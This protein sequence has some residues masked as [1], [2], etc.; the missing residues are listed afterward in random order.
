M[1]A[2]MIC[3][4]GHDSRYLKFLLLLFWNTVPYSNVFGQK[5]VIAFLLESVLIE[6]TLCLATPPSYLIHAGI[7]SMT[8]WTRLA[9]KS[10]VQ[11]L[12]RESLRTETDCWSSWELSMG[13]K[14]LRGRLTTI[15]DILQVCTV[16]HLFVSF[17]IFCWIMCLEFELLFA[18]L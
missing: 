8:R 16:S 3:S 5:I 17:Y 4:P 2:S 7:I 6:I 1:L 10:E 18:L 13:Q 12:C 11:Y 15:S 14:G 9:D